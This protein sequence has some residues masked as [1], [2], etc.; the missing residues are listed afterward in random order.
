MLPDDADL[1]PRSC[2]KSSG[3]GDQIVQLAVAESRINTRFCHFSQ[4][5]NALRGGLIQKDR[6]MSAVHKAAIFEAL[7]NEAL[8]L[9]NREVGHMHIVDQG[10]VDVS[11]VAHSCFCR[12][13]WHV[14][15]ADFQQIS[16]AEPQQRRSLAAIV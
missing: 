2:G 3:G 16:S 1:S 14:V 13:L 10:Q 7:L 15:N 9:L 12:E 6:D 11:R 4:N 5:R 8:R